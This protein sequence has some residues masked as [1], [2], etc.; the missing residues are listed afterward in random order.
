MNY[1]DPATLPPGTKVDQYAISGVLG[2]GGFGITYLVH[3]EA[4]QKDFA[5]K[6]FFPEDLVMR[7]G[8]SIRFTARPHSESDYRWGLKKFY[9]EARL[10]AQF[11]HTNIVSVRRVFEGN[12]T[13]YM[14]LDFV[15]GSTL[16]KWLSG[17][18]SPPT[19][20]ELD[21]IATPLLS[22]L[23][24]VH[25]NRA[26]HLDISPDNVMIR[27]TDGAPILLDF[28]ASRFEIKQHSQLVSALVFKSGYSA[29]EQY[30]SN[31][32]RYGPWTDIYAFAA[33]L[34][35]A[36]SGTRPIEATS[37]QLA[38]DLRPAVLVGKGRYR[39]KFLKAIDWALKL[40][41]QDR[42][43][44]IPEWRKNL[45]EGG[46]APVA[47]AK[48][49]VLSGRTRIVE[50]GPNPLPSLRQSV[51]PARKFPFGA[52][53]IP[54]SATAAVAALGVLLFA[55]FGLDRLAPDFR[56]NPVTLV[57]QALFGGSAGA[58]CGSSASCWGVVVEKNGGVFARVNEPTK[59]EAENGAMNLC[60]QRVGP[61]GCR[62]ISV[63]SKK[64][65][66]ALAEVPSNPA[67][68]RGANGATLDEAKTSAKATC[69]TNYGFCRVGMTFCA[70]GG[71]RVGGAD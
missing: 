68:W 22:A 34:Y 12:N 47:M 25:A 6:E 56:L 29:P 18:D 39:D 62:V 33:T 41:P 69:E 31:A 9:D 8:T 60:A 42:P 43:Q 46:G 19:Q 23:E 57:R 32:D 71:N 58:L 20:E 38:D 37:R 70:D 35:R 1:Q 10:L 48:T 45:L 24:L 49:R 30:T 36:I 53:D 54:T 66:W 44:S 67:D 16:E 52:L 14:L 28:G 51:P 2:R 11:S 50:G 26:W 40:P 59:E 65:C 21:L 61:G 3:D 64:E 4:L 55:G 17:L 7:E 27:A 5:L 15:R 63:L 13:A